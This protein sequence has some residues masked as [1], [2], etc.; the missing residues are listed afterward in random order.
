MRRAWAAD[1]EAFE[2]EQAAARAAWYEDAA[3]SEGELRLANTL[4]HG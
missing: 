4:R 2:K 3:Q 1:M